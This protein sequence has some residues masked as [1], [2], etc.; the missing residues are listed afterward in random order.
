MFEETKKQMETAREIADLDVL[1][2]KAL[3][4]PASKAGVFESAAFSWLHPKR[5]GATDD[6]IADL[7]PLSEYYQQINPVLSAA[8]WG[9]WNTLDYLHR[10]M[11]FTFSLLRRS[12]RTDKR[13]FKAISALIATAAIQF[14]DGNAAT[15]VTSDAKENFSSYRQHAEAALRNLS[16]LTM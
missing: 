16:S 6:F 11:W 14:S 12:R 7:R 4:A 13:L 2:V 9:I 3:F 5:K 15:V 8:I 10:P 1:L